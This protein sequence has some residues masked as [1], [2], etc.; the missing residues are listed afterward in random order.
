M[1]P[2]VVYESMFGNTR[3]VA[4][5][6]GSGLSASCEVVVCAV[7]AL[8]PGDLEGVTL[9]V[10][11]GP[12]HAWGLSRPKTRAAAASQA[13]ESG[14]TMTLEP[15]ATGIGLR[16][17]LGTVPVHHRQVAVFDTRVALPGMVTGRAATKIAALLRRRG[18]LVIA[19]PESFLVTKKAT[20]LLPGEVERAQ[21][22]GRQLA[23]STASTTLR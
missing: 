21:S 13:Q 20:R 14:S 7:G 10:V 3:A 11:G 5:A 1:R 19:P 12:T 9:L 4:E 15:G 23:E 16:E 22:W 18:G 17:W 2:L 6:I 8:K